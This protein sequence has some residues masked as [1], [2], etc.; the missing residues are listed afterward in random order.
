MGWTIG[1]VCVMIAGFAVFP[2]PAQNPQGARPETRETRGDKTE[3][4][5]NGQRTAK[6]KELEASR[7]QLRAAYRSGDPAAIKIAREN[8]QKQ[9]SEARERYGSAPRTK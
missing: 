7:E 5:K 8:Y 9:R 2:A 6:R 1:A 4:V 3:T